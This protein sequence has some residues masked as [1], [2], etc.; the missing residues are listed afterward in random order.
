MVSVFVKQKTVE[1]KGG[2]SH[3]RCAQSA[4]NN[5]WWCNKPTTNKTMNPLKTLRPAAYA[6]LGMLGLMHSASAQLLSD[7]NPL[8]DSA[9]KELG[10]TQ[11]QANL[12]VAFAKGADN[13]YSNL[14]SSFWETAQ[15]DKG[16]M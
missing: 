9:V 16:L 1:G 13:F 6:L 10:A 15:L 7:S 8:S 14:P 4:I 11:N 2:A 12:V 5:Y 3:D